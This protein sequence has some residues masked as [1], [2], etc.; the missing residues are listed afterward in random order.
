MSRILLAL[1]CFLAV[2]FGGRMPVQAAAFLPAPPKPPL[3]EKAP[4]K[5]PEKIV[6]AEVMPAAPAP[7]PP[8]AAAAA[9]AAAAAP[10]PAA[11][12][13]LSGAARDAVRHLGAVQLLGLL[14]RE[15]RLVDFLMEDID[16]YADAQIGAAVRDIHRGCKKALREHMRVA[17]IRPE[18]DESVVKIQAGFDPS[19]VRLVG[20]VTGRPP[21]EGA[22]RHHGW[23]AESLRI[24][25]LPEGYDATVVCPA[26]VELG[27]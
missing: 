20:Q 27:A 18:A 15:G 17:P 23:R 12:A 9:A 11:A 8:P 10:P 16:S 14:Q 2:L 25:D 21:F 5:A 4:E 22:L 24:S 7:A 26:E 13:P 3:P 6:D 1:R 19:Q